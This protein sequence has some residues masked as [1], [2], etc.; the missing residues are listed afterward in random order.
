MVREVQRRALLP[1]TALAV[2]FLVIALVAAWVLFMG[3]ALGMVGSAGW[4]WQA[5]AVPVVLAGIGLLFMGI[6]YAAHAG[7]DPNRGFPDRLVA[8][9]GAPVA[10]KMELKPAGTGTRS[11]RAEAAVGAY[12]APPPRSLKP[13]SKSPRRGPRKE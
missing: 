4:N 7:A 8:Y 1:L 12:P 13:S 11:T 6:R 9:P 2:V 3:W 10:H 5:I